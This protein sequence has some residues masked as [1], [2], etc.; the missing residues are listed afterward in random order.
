[1]K[2]LIATDMEGITGVMHWDQVTPGH[3]EYERFRKLMTWDVNAA[4]RGAADAGVEEFVVVDGHW[5]GYNILI[6]ELDSRARL[7]SGTG[8]PLA[9]VEGAAN[10]IDAAFFIGYHARAGSLNA[11]LDHTWS[12]SRVYNVWMNDMLVG[13]TGLNAAVCGHFGAP[14]LLVSGDQTLAAEAAALI[15][16][17]ETAIV[18]TASARMSAECLPP[19][20]SEQVIY[21]KAYKAIQQFH[22]SKS[23]QPFVPG[24]P[25]TLKV[26]LGTTEMADHAALL[27]GAHRLDGRSFLLKA[28]SILDAYRSF[29]GLIALTRS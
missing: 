3:N 6:E 20:E 17:I 28:D 1:M 25:L 8:G 7:V 19:E 26:E 29:E 13:E 16:G 10:G 21:S 27:P 4:I 9:M 22:S 11:I 24:I 18:K 2:L 14:V 23:P 5:F 12:S 15:P